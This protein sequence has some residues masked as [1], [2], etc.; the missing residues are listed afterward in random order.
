MANVLREKYKDYKT[1]YLSWDA[2]SWHMSK[3]LGQHLEQCNDRA[4]ADTRPVIKV[5]P[6]PSGAQFLNVIE[7]VF[8]GLARAVIHNS[9]YPDAD[10][11]RVAVDQ[12]LADRN[13]HYRLHPERAGNSIWGKERVPSI[14]SEA[15]NCKDP[16]YQ[17]VV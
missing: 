10:A 3:A 13:E 15:N 9:D 4:I 2:A 11:A 12:H 8:S 14:F 5:A 16:A 17:F 6:L 7:S 1:L